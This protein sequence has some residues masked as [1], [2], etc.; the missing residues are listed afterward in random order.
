MILWVDAHISPKLWR[1]Q[2][3]AGCFR[4]FQSAVL[5]SGSRRRAASSSSLVAPSR[6]NAAGPR[7][8]PRQMV[9]RVTCNAAARSRTETEPPRWPSATYATTS[10]ASL[11]RYPRRPLLSA[12]GG[13]SIRAATCAMSSSSPTCRSPLSP[14][15]T[16]GRRAAP[17]AVAART[18]GCREH[19][20]R[21]PTVLAPAA[22]CPR[23]VTSYGSVSAPRPPTLD[24]AP[25]TNP[26][27]RRPGTPHA[28][29]ASWN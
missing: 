14:A 5:P 6:A 26:P 20:R 23:L 15:A 3:D 25:A 27:P 13:S 18:P 17:P 22:V 29:A 28:P 4:C 1:P 2:G 12:A 7:W 24:V 19:A 11:S 8:K 10:R 21:T 16:R 9:T